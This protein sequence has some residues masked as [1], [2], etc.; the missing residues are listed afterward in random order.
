MPFDD[1]P[2]R[3]DGDPGAEGILNTNLDRLF[4]NFRYFAFGKA[5]LFSAV[6]SRAIVL[7]P[8]F[9]LYTQILAGAL[10]E[11]L[12]GAEQNQ[13][14]Q[15]TLLASNAT[16][17][18]LAHSISRTALVIDL[19]N[20][21]IPPETRAALAALGLTRLLLNVEHWD[22]FPNALARLLDFLRQ[23]VPGTVLIAG[24]VHAGSESR[25]IP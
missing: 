3:A 16:W 25:T 9:Q 20:P 6:G 10:E 18:I 5:S 7:E 8:T 2:D 17:R 23:N 21:L 4:P 22:G 11:D 12:L 19:T 13:F 14:I 15:D 24:D 1:G